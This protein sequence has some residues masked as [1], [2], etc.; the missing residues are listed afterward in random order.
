[1]FDELVHVTKFFENR[2]CP[3]LKIGGLIISGTGASIPNVVEV[4]QKETGLPTT[5]AE[6]FKNVDTHRFPVPV[7]LS[8]TF[9]D[10]I[11]LAMRN[12]E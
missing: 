10:A 5:L 11:G 2:V 6:P 9:A 1:M 7:E 4:F 3:G 12:Y 8:H